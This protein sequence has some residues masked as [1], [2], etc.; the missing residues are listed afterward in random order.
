ME[1][2]VQMER[3]AFAEAFGVEALKKATDPCRQS[4]QNCPGHDRVPQ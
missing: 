3:A 4:P 2:A 1:M